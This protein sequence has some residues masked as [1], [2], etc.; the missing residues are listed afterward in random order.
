M[1]YYA[2]QD[3]FAIDSC[4]VFYI[5]YLSKLFLIIFK[6]KNFFI[7]NFL[8]DKKKGCNTPEGRHRKMLEK[9]ERQNRVSQKRSPMFYTKLS[10]AV[11]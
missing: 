3:E 8:N 2:K 5:I 9:I 11:S 1:Y 4:V 7:M 10:T 6:P